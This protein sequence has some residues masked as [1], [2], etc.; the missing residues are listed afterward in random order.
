MFA[1]LCSQ[2]HSGIISKNKMA[3]GDKKLQYIFT[4]T[5]LIWNCVGQI[6]QCKLGFTGVVSESV[7]IYW[8]TDRHHAIVS[9]P[10]Q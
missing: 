4:R 7:L 2:T 3:C 5:S 9:L 6:T 8:D 10:D 1:G